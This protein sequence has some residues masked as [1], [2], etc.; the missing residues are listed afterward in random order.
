MW[1]TL[2]TNRTDVDLNVL[3]EHDV[4]I[5]IDKYKQTNFKST[6]A[7]GILLGYRKGKFVHVTSATTP[8][9]KDKRSRFAFF[10]NDIS[11]QL[12]ALESWKQ[13][14]GYMDYLGE[15]H[16][17]PEAHPTPSTIDITEWGKIYKTVK[18]PMI[19]LILGISNDMWL[20]YINNDNII[21]LNN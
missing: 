19:F 20:G 16:T 1:T 6:E 13:S 14:Q 11:H 5:L 3:I 7:G 15:W 18:R 8:Q 21:Q 12:Q 4:F 10:R 17:H 2:I 9:A